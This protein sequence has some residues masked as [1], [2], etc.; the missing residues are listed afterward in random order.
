MTSW[1]DL[2]YL[3][4]LFGGQSILINRIERNEEKRFDLSTF[5][6]KRNTFADFLQ[7]FENN[8]ERGR[9]I[10]FLRSEIVVNPQL[11]ADYQRPAFITSVL[12]NRHTGLTIWE[13]FDRKPEWKD[14]ERYYCLVS[15]KEEFALVSPTFKQ[16]IYSGILEELEPT[17]TP[18]DLFQRLNEKKYPLT[19]YA[20]VLQVKLVPGQCLY[21]PAY[22]WVQTR[23]LEDHSVM[24]NFEYEA[25]SE[26]ATLFF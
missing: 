8:T 10:Y 15:G 13:P 23:T 9:A 17:E 3:S 1:R 21:V 16:A 2:R 24:L 7:K 4:K 5:S 14:R 26:L 12:R 20:E 18:F 19:Q 11:K 6:S 25:H 22:Y